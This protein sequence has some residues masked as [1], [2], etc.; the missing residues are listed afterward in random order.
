M[1]TLALPDCVASSS[2]M[3]TTVSVLG[4]GAT[5]GAVYAPPSEMAPHKLFGLQ[6][7][8]WICQMTFWLLVPRTEAVNPC[9]PSG[10]SVTLLGCTLTSTWLMT[11][12]CAE[13]VKLGLP[14]L[15]TI[16]D[17]GFV[18]GIAPGAR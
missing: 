11:V 14:A 13:A 1:V 12:I 7:A 3:A 15:V 5:P 2:L 8:P 10:G 4:V 18:A 17:T 9:T 6:P 16:T